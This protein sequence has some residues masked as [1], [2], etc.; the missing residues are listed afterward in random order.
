MQSIKMNQCRD[1]IAWKG[2]PR[3]TTEQMLRPSD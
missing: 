2:Q 1:T 3:D